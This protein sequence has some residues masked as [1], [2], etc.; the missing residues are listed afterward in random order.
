[1]VCALYNSEKQRLQELVEG[2][3]WYEVSESMIRRYGDGGVA[4]I[5]QW[6]ASHAGY[7]VGTAE[8]TFS[9]RIREDRQFMGFSQESTFTNVCGPPDNE[10]DP[11]SC[12]RPSYWRM[13]PVPESVFSSDRVGASHQEL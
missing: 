8:S 11:H 6:I 13:V 7:F 9:F 1:M 5:D 12:E 10:S 3:V 2:L 4:I